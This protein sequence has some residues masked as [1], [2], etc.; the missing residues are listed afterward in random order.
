MRLAGRGEKNYDFSMSKVSFL[1]PVG[2]PI[3]TMP[4][5][6]I[7]RVR[8]D[9]PPAPDPTAE[10]VY[11]ALLFPNRSLPST[12]FAIV[13]GIVIAVN[14]TLGL[15]F[16]TLGAWPVIGFSGLDILLVWLAFKIS[17]RQGRLHERVR[18]AD[19][20]MLVSRVLPSGHETRWKLQTAWT[21]VFIDD[22]DDHQSCVRVVSKGRVLFLGA[23]LSP[24]ERVAFGE[25]LQQAVANQ[26]G[27]LQHYE[28]A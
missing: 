26:G 18:V 6:L 4:P 23:F 21:R 24:E 14:L 13:M 2:T 11:E 7:G 12:G 9:R 1:K 3:E 10:G 28:R 17:Y 25:A 19:G 20:V 22:P 5:T 27:V 16:Y 8:Y 15:F